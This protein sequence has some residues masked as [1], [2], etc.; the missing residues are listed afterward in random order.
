MAANFIKMVV[1]SV[2][3]WYLPLIAGLIFIGVGIYSFMQP[4]ESYLALTIVFSLAFLFNGISDIA[5]AVANRENME[6]WGWDLA[7][8]I[9]T[10]LVGILLISNPAISML[11]LPFYVGFVVMFRS[12]SAIGTSLE[13]KK[14]YVQDWGY[15]LAI[16]ILGVIFSFILLFN[17]GFAGLSIVIWTAL[18]FITIGIFSIYFS[19][20][21]KKL[22]DIPKNI[23]KEVKKRFEDVTLE[24]KK[25]ILDQVDKLKSAQ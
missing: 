7:M 14:Y 24:V 2:K 15:L 3:H 21:L 17:P 6:G 20:K 9:L 10:T 23:S 25:E 4:V 13:L 11:T 12:I 5:F 18:A 22:H 19:L 8:G 16:G 1:N